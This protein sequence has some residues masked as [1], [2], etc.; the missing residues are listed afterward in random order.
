MKKY[1]RSEPKYVTDSDTDSGPLGY[2][3]RCFCS[4]WLWLYC[5]MGP[6]DEILAEIKPPFQ[7]F[8]ISI[9]I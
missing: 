8:N 2:E 3:L 5:G 4:D 6:I 7:R 1:K 9:V